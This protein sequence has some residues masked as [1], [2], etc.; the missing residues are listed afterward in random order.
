[1]HAAALMDDLAAVCGFATEIEHDC[2]RLEQDYAY[3]ESFV[4]E[5]VS[6]GVQSNPVL[7]PKKYQPCKDF[8]RCTRLDAQ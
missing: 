6:V 2:A 8:L 3:L 5:D 1:M 7:S 4:P